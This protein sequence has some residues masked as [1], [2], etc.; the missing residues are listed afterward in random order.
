MIAGLAVAIP[1][2]LL[3][4]ITPASR[5]TPHD[6]PVGVT[7]ADAAVEQVRASLEQRQ[8]GAFDVQA[9]AT[10]EDLHDATRDRDIYGGFVLGA[11]PETVIATG[12][13]AAVGPMLT[14]IADGIAAQS[15][16]PAPQVVDVAPPA[17]DDPRGAGFGSMVM[18]VFMTGMALGIACALVGRRR[19]LIAVML[20]IGAAVVGATAVGVGMAAGVLAGG[21]ALQWLALSVGILAM[22]ASVAGVVSLMGVRGVGVVAVLFMLIGM[23]LAGISAPH[24]FLSPVWA[25]LGQSLPLGATGTAL[26]SASFFGGAGSLTAFA[27]LS[28]WILVGYGMLAV[29]RAASAPQEPAAVPQRSRPVAPSPVG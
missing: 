24:E 3:M 21:F 23:P 10:A 22:A 25:T 8:P 14:Q 1:L 17:A 28:A 12:A 20:P 4:F 18:P 15:G 7:G 9:F 16:G 2:V 13:S 26:R 11:A 6:L 19:R 27:V 29:R 5:G